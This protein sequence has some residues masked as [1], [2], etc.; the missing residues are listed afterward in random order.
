M[1]K[2]ILHTFELW[3]EL[4]INYD[5]SH[6]IFMGK[7]DVY[8]LIIEKIIGCPRGVFSIKYLGVPLRETKLRKED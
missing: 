4:K 2:W 1:W 6:I 3:S 7:I 5:K 8:Y